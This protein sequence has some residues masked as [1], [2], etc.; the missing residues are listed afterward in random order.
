MAHA[1]LTISSRAMQDCH[2]QPMP[3]SFLLPSKANFHPMP[4]S[5]LLPSMANFQPPVRTQLVV[6]REYLISMQFPQHKYSDARHFQL[7]VGKP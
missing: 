7:L 3:S 1:V 5:F 6:L 4:S 2:Q